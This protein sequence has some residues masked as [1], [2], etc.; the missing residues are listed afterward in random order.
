MGRIPA[1]RPRMGESVW[2]AAVEGKLRPGN[3]IH[4]FTRTQVLKRAARAAG[5]ALA[6][7]PLPH[8]CAPPLPRTR[9]P[10]R[11][12]PIPPPGPPAGSR[13]PTPRGARREPAEKWGGEQGKARRGR[14]RS[15]RRRGARAR[16]QADSSAIFKGR[17]ARRAN[18]RRACG[19]GAWRRRTR[20]WLLRPPPPPRSPQSPRPRAVARSLV[21]AQALGRR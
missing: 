1:F 9:A 8:T 5:G 10:P 11:P 13:A 12:I 21:P 19:G 18:G 14:R 7:R 15:L 17:P 3:T 2:H 20:M 16:P 6:P 4:R